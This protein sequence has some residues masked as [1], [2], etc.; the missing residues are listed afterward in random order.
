MNYP[1]LDQLKKHKLIIKNLRKQQYELYT[2]AE[3]FEKYCIDCAVND[4]P[5]KWVLFNLVDPFWV[6]YLCKNFGQLRVKL[7]VGLAL[8]IAIILAEVAVKLFVPGIPS[9][10]SAFSMSM[11]GAATGILTSFGAAIFINHCS[12]LIYQIRND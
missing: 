4:I 9:A 5:R 12:E 7:A 2:E 11:I 3:S 6:Y 1:R 10:I 8:S